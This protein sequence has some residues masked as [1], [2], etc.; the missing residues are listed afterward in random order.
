MD[1]GRAKWIAEG[2]PVSTD[3]PKPG[4]ADYPD[5]ARDDARIRAFKDQV[6][7]HL[8]QPLIDVRS[9]G[10]YTGEL[11]HMPDYPQEGA[12]RGGHIPGARSVPWSRAAAA[13]ATFRPRA[14]PEAIYAGE[15]ELRPDDYV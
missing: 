1:G 2:R 3:T 13:D 4:A 11:L 10:E 8:G 15:A 14:E 6:L 5:I 9:P 7:A 12:V